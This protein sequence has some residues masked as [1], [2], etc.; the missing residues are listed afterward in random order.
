M[1]HEGKMVG[2]GTHKQLLAKCPDY[3][4]LALSQMSEEELGIKEAYN[5]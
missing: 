2:Q 4:A 1:L 5:G 3:R